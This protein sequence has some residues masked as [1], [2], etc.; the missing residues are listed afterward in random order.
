MIWNEQVGESFFFAGSLPQR[1]RHRALRPGSLALR[2][3]ENADHPDNV[4]YREGEDYEVDAERGEIVRLPGGRLPDGGTHPFYGLD[5]FDHVRDWVPF[6]GSFIV[7]G[8]YEFAEG[9]EGATDSVRQP[10]TASGGEGLNGPLGAAIRKLAAGDELR[11]AMFG[12][13]ICIGSDLEN[14]ERSSF[15]ERWVRELRA[16]YPEADIK[17]RNY[18]VGGEASGQGLSRLRAASLE[19]R[20]DLVVIGFGMNDQNRTDEGGHAVPLA[21]FEANLSAMIDTVRARMDADIA[22]LTPCLPNP[23]WRYAHPQARMFAETIRRVGLLH[24]AAVADAQLRFEAAL[25]AGKTH[26]SLLGSHVN[27]P[28]AYG[29]ALYAEALVDLFG[30]VEA[31]ARYVHRAGLPGGA[32][33]LGSQLFINA[34]D[35]EDEVRGWVGQ[36]ADHGLKLIRLFM[37][38]EQLESEKGRWRFDVYDACFDEAA[39]RGLG[40][41]PTL[42]AVSPPGWQRITDGPQGVA[43]LDESTLKERMGGY[44]GQVVRRYAQHPALH[45]WILWNEP[46]RKIRRSPQAMAGYAEYA[47]RA[48]GTIEAFNRI[49]YW[50][51]A[52]FEQLAAQGTGPEGPELPFVSFAER[53]DWARFSVDNLNAILRFIRDEVRRWD[54]VHPVHVNP[55]NLQGEMQASGQSLWAESESVDFLGCSAH[56]AWHS[57]RFPERRWSQS[58]AFFSD[59]THSASGRSDELFWVTELQGGPTLYSAGTA[60]CPTAEEIRQ[61]IWEGIGAGARAVVFWCFNARKGGYEAAEWSLLNQLGEPSPR[62]EAVRDA[63]SILDRETA[64]FERAK[65]AAP[66]VY[67]LY[68][69]ASCALGQA[70]GSGNDPANPRNGN[71]YL[72]AIAGAYLMLSDLSVPAGFIN[73]KRLRE[74]GVPPGTRALIVPNAIVL[75]AE[76]SAA[77]EAY[78]L[79]GGLVIGDGLIGMKDPNGNV[80]RKTLGQADALFGAKVLELETAQDRFDIRFGTEGTGL[81]RIGFEGTRLE[82][83]FYR[84]PLAADGAETIGRFDHGGA[85]AVTVRREGQGAALR[86]GTLLFQRYFAAP[87]ANSLALLAAWLGDR[88]GEPVRLANGDRRL[89]LRRLTHAEGELLIL[90]NEGDTAEA[91]LVF[92]EPGLLRSLISPEAAEKGT[93]AGGTT[94]VPIGARGIEV[95]AYVKRD[96][97]EGGKEIHG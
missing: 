75:G 92:A 40:I 12:D 86:I 97:N 89:R 67:V 43:N 65:T 18:A 81:E 54:P 34:S 83:W 85:A 27:H 29:H 82:G 33:A 87:S 35:T 57:L 24:G 45:S 66:R 42:M 37:I 9:S 20:W 7:Y 95:L 49:S 30:P 91:E 58:V 17:L 41:V 74:N 69:E 1:C 44:I 55:H 46:S 31:E 59:L 5:P 38:W 76:E 8:D 10:G 3:R 4:T 16:R 22:L 48:Y 6:E 72:D 14:K 56:P 80:D 23:R 19:E 93:A 32:L 94:R 96:R 39:R 64:L 50:K 52:S 77:L 68:S 79:G 78:V 47:R 70:E 63:A 2:S 15:A 88:S 60:H 71:M 11:I 28:S 51:F 90:L 25:A 61:W 13:S 53:T 36:M 62:L 21:T 84:L 26:E 73:E